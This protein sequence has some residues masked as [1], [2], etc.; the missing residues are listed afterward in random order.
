M[1]LSFSC[2]HNKDLKALS[3][4]QFK[5]HGT[6]YVEYLGLPFYRLFKLL[7]ANFGTSFYSTIVFTKILACRKPYIL[8]KF[9]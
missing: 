1:I 6:K 7:E 9:Y 8:I 3:F 2:D 5:G 4:W